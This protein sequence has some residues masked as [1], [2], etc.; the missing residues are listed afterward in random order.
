[1]I[2]STVQLTEVT[3]ASCAVAARAARAALI[4]ASG[5]PGETRSDR[6]ATVA[7]KQISSQIPMLSRTD[8]TTGRVGSTGFTST[9]RSRR[10]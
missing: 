10:S 8:S 6:N 4:P 5:A 2:G 9:G 3:R 7:G 1:M